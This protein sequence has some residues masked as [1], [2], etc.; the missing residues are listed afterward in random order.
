MIA[1]TRVQSQWSQYKRAH[2]RQQGEG[3][4]RRLGHLVLLG[5]AQQPGHGLGPLGVGEAVHVLDEAVDEDPVAVVE[6]A[7][8]QR[9]VNLL[10]HQLLLDLVLG[11]P[12]QLPPQDDLPDAV[13]P[14]EAEVVDE[15]ED[16]EDSEDE[17]PEPEE[18][19]DL[20]VEDVDGQDALRVVLLDVAAGSV[21]VEGALGDPREHAGHRVRAALLGGLHEGGGRHTVRGELVAEEQVREEDLEDDVDEVERVADE[22]PDG[23]AVVVSERVDEVLGEGGDA[24]PPGLLVEVEPVEGPDQPLH[25][26]TLQP[27]VDHVGD[28]EH[29]TL[30][31]ENIR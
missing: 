9:D 3:L 2:L 11:T 15:V 5:L 4:R 6:V 26:V 20:L 10:L 31:S 19:V 17:E 18:D 22:G 28:V 13:E 12:P 21:L 7:A 8:D 27:L 16:G 23:P 25:L 14:H 24:V 29:D 1:A 30:S